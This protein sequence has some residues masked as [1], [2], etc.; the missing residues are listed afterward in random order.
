MP[1]HPPGMGNMVAPQQVEQH[2]GVS[3]LYPPK[4]RPQVRSLTGS[5]SASNESSGS[6]QLDSLENSAHSSQ[7]SLGPRPPLGVR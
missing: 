5:A 2:A 6:A 3:T 1:R 7:I 4:S